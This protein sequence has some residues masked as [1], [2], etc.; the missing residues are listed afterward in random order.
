MSM[1]TDAIIVGLD[2][3]T[4]KVVA[5][6]A[7][8]NEHGSIDI[9]GVGH[10]ESDGVKRG[11]INNIDK[12]VHAIRMAIEQVESQAGLEVGVVHVSMSGEHMRSMQQKG[13][14][15]L[16][17]PD[18]EISQE[19]LQRL[20]QDMYKVHVPMGWEIVHVLPQEYTVDNQADI[21]DPVGM[22]GV[23]LEG[24][25]HIVMAQS[26]SLRNLTRCIR[27]AGLEIAEVV[28]Q[29][30]ASAHAVLSDEEKEAG[31]CLVDIGGGTTDLI[32]YEDELIR[33]TGVIPFGGNIVTEDIK[34]GC[35]VMSRQAELLK[36]RYG[37]A[38][39]TMLSDA[40]EIIT[41]SGL[42]NRPAKDIRTVTLANII[43][44]RLEEIL[45]FVA[46]EIEKSGYQHKLVGGIVLTGGGAQLRHLCDLTE[47]VTGIDTR[48]GLPGKQY[49]KGMVSELADAQFAA[50]A[51]LCAYGLSQAMLELETPAPKAAEPRRRQTPGTSAAEPKRNARP[52]PP[53]NGADPATGKL[54]TK[55]KK[56]FETTVTG[57]PN[58]ID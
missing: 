31:V 25:F 52:V 5:V 51:G 35:G 24:N 21:K 30:Y 56:W 53:A 22:S 12:T 44:A 57:G 20:K 55:V 13:I 50:A 47:F 46:L 42:S 15:T 26:N 19:D 37:S 27:R 16:N 18:S 8:Y 29:P 7:K 49:A 17:D 4:T 40:D 45:E 2:I 38:L 1:Y 33:H 10:A 54:V 3:G 58:T 28:F 48:L 11:E 6:A 41:I 36:R 39:A 34:H 23:R 32:I 14:I 43:Q 9:L